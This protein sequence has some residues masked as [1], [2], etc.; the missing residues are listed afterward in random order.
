MN[1][2][3]LHETR[4]FF[5]AKAATW[6]EKYPD[7][8][9]VFA[10]AIAEM[11]LPSGGL[12]LDAGCGTGR[13]FPLLRDAVGPAGRVVGVD[14]TPEMIRSARDRGRADF[15]LLLIADAGRLPLRDGVADGVL[16]SG[17]ISHVPRP[18]AV[19]AELARVTRPG[20]RLALFHPVGRAVLAARR[21]RTL[22]PDDLRAERNLRPL[23]DAA[24]WTL[25]AF[26][27][28]DERYL[29]LARR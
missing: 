14:V 10:A 3:S 29:A 19:L 17:L 23:L 28:T 8:G 6:E 2:R 25:L 26:H 21:G 27:D 1:E 15:G 11:A 18:A 5:A 9:P 16:A 20:G 13:A 4:E 22:T 7:D 12:V 24:G